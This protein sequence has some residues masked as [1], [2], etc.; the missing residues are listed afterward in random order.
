MAE[1]IDLEEFCQTVR[2]ELTELA[3]NNYPA[4][5]RE[6]TGMLD[7]VTSAENRAGYDQKYLT[8]D[9]EEAPPVSTTAGCQRPSLP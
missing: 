2:Q 4:L 1:S 5:K 8:D 6:A 7:A 3:G 9:G